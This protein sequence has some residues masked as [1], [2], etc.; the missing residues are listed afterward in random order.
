[1]T[2][3]AHPATNLHGEAGRKVLAD[4]QYVGSRAERQVF[5]DAPDV[6]ENL[7]VVLRDNVIPDDPG[8]SGLVLD[9]PQSVAPVRLPLDC[10][11]LSTPHDLLINNPG[12]GFCTVNR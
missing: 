11:I 3:L 5:E 6:G 9:Q 10:R 1:M 7:D 8:L 12:E 2:A 4:N